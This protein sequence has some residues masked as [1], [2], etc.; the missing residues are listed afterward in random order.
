MAEYERKENSM[1]RQTMLDAIKHYKHEA[2]PH[3]PHSS[4]PATIKDIKKV[5]DETAKLM[6]RLVDQLNS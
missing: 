1:D 4:D 2:D 5:I 6:T 3:N